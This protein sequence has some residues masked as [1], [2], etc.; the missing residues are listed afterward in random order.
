MGDHI[1]GVLAIHSYS[2]NVFDQNQA[3][4]LSA[5]SGTIGSAI[6]NAR[7]YSEME[8]AREAAEAANAAKSIFLASISHELRTPLNAILG[9]AQLL[10]R[11]SQLTPGQQA[12]LEII[13]RRGI[14]LLDLINDVLEISRIESGRTLLRE[15]DIDLYQ[16]FDN[17]IEMYTLQAKEK[18]LA[19]GFV[20]AQDIPQHVRLDHLKL[21]HTLSNL[22]GNAIKFTRSGGVSVWVSLLAAS[23]DLATLEFKV[24]DTGPGISPEELEI[25]FVP[26][27]QAQAG[28]QTQGG[29]GLGLSICRQYVRLLGGE[30]QVKSEPGVGSGFTFAIQVR[31][32]DPAGVKS[33]QP[34]RRVIG[35]DPNQAPPQRGAYR[36]LVAEDDESNRL[37][38]VN[39]LKMPG[40][41]IQEAV[42]GQEAV[43]IWGRWKPD[44]VFMD[45]HM[46]VLDGFSATRQIKSSPGGH[47]SVII[48]LTASSLEE[49]RERVLSAG[50]DDFIGKP[51]QLDDVYDMLTRHL[52]IK[53]IYQEMEIPEPARPA[54]NGF[55]TAP[56]G[57]AGPLRPA[58]QPV[59]RPAPGHRPGRYPAHAAHHPG[60]PGSGCARRSHPGAAGQ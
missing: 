2:Q 42:N 60:H 30:L 21:W 47:S 46:P 19:F 50:C 43:K 8:K 4:L 59:G 34:P 14:N 53:F 17:L 41:K 26:F 28:Q 52:G 23:D 29:V 57:A 58:R 55:S 10:R 51:Y 6:E 56:P 48:A 20:Y 5:L 1:L 7:L 37:L 32:V 38:L 11:D 36:L 3:R 25:I 54:E 40:F 44:L 16:M 33:T 24:E 22:I 27:V 12:Y 49:D 35:L 45:M 39:A 31:K 15:N 13:N 18:G 9:F